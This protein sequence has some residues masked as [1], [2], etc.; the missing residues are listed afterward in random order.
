M[1][2]EE[3]KKRKTPRLQCFDYSSVGVYFLTLCTQNRQC[4]LS[5]VVGTGVPD[6]PGEPQNIIVGT[7]VPDCPQIQLTQYGEIAEKY[8]K[9]IDA[10]Y[11][12]LSVESYV[13][14]PNH[15]H[16]LL[17]V[18]DNGQSRTPVPTNVTRANSVVS[19]FVSTFKRF[20]N[21]E[22]GQNIWQSRYYDHIIRNRN[23][24]EEH[25]RYIYENPMRWYYDELYAEEY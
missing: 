15:V 18:K 1:S 13:I 14:M 22:Y 10:F 5:R 9:Q 25:M 3:W 23:D 2:S 19:Q 17:F 16:L 24:H 20:C 7:G 12:H 8:I 6:C 4:I 21:K 11:E